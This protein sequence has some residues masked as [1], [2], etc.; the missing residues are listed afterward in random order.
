MAQEGMGK[1]QKAA[2]SRRGPLAGHILFAHNATARI[3]DANIGKQ[4][5]N[6][7]RRGTHG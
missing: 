4:A 6:G 5:G 3:A 2:G 1:G 7:L